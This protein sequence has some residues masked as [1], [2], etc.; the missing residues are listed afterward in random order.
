MSSVIGSMEVRFVNKMRHSVSTY[1]CKPLFLHF[2]RQDRSTTTPID[3]FRLTMQWKWALL[4]LN[5][6]QVHPMNSYYIQP[7][8]TRHNRQGHDSESACSW[9]LP[10]WF[11]GHKRSFSEASDEIIY[12]KKGYSFI[13]DL[14]IYFQGLCLAVMCGGTWNARFYSC[15]LWAPTYAASE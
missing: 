12:L 13:W 2:Y 15:H 6:W 7:P 5:T 8:V 11:R 4:P 9:H 14:I 3:A 1:F 10:G